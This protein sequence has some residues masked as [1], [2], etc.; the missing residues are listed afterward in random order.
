VSLIGRSAAFGLPMVIA[1]LFAAAGQG[2][3]AALVA[4]V[5]VVQAM[6]VALLG[7]RTK[8]RSLDRI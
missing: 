7:P 2:G 4:C 5:L 1:P 8:G 6:L 3:V